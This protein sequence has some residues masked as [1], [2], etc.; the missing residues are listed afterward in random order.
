MPE[1]GPTPQGDVI[2]EIVMAWSHEGPA[3]E[4]AGN[5]ILAAL[6][7]LED[8]VVELERGQFSSTPH[9]ALVEENASLQAQLAVVEAEKT[10]TYDG[11]SAMEWSIEYDALHAMMEKEEARS[12]HFS[13]MAQAEDERGVQLSRRLEAAEAET[14]VLMAAYAEKKARAEQLESAFDAQTGLLVEANEMLT[15]LRSELVKVLAAKED[16]FNRYTTASADRDRAV[17]QEK[18]AWARFDKYGWEITYGDMAT[19][20]RNIVNAPWRSEE[21]KQAINDAVLLLPENRE[22]TRDV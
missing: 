7:E 13:R 9:K 22:E 12:V 4:A 5:R 19:A 17:E 16:W 11:K 18:L 10:A 8:R 21:L 3:A 15:L 14:E 20:L 1:T 6:Y 2:R